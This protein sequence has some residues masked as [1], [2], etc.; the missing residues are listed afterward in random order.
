MKG[1]SLLHIA[2]LVILLFSLLTVTTAENMPQTIENVLNSTVILN[3]KDAEGEQL[4]IGRG[5]FVSRNYVVTNI[6]IVENAVSGS[7]QLVNKKTR[8]KIES[9]TDYEEYSLALLRVNNSGVRPLGLGDSDAVQYGDTVRVISNPSDRVL[10]GQVKNRV[11]DGIKANNRN[12][13]LRDRVITA[14]YYGKAEWIRIT[15]R[16]SHR[17]SGSP[18]LNKKNEIIGVADH[19]GGAEWQ[20]GNYAVSSKTL[21]A[22]LAKVKVEPELEK[23]YDVNPGGRLTVDSDIGTVNV[24]AAPKNKVEIVVTKEPKNRF[25]SDKLVQE[26]LADFKVTF[27]QTGSNVSVTGKFQRGRNYWRRQINRL[28]IRFRVT[29]PHQY[30]VNL[31]TESGDISVIGLE[32]EVQAQ[33]SAGNIGIENV[34]GPV[35]TQTNAGNL[36]FDRVNGYILGRSSAGNII[37]FNCQGMVDAKTSA[38]N[39]RADMTTQLKRE[40]NLQTL[41]GNIVGTF[42][43]SLAVD[44]DARTGAGISSTD[45]RVQGTVNRTRLYGTI[46]GGGALLKLRTSAGNIHLQSLK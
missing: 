16:I 46:N 36:R 27:D 34:V 19:R 28:N 20:L 15:P 37:L 29:V 5:F 1:H 14:P 45:F 44:I 21:A 42:I 9:V 13:V 32:G 33:S 35:E 38:G 6:H 11:V 10:E 4:K 25:V 22:L 31:H 24:Q 39:I 8:F 12:V 2:T 40:W 30:D 41:A 18:V 7:V 43:S 26:A 23:T 3:L 17:I